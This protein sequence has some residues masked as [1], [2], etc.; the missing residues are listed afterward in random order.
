MTVLSDGWPTEAAGIAAVELV[1]ARINT[2]MTAA[3]F[4]H[5]DAATRVDAVHVRVRGWAADA[6]DT[7]PRTVHLYADTRFVGSTVA[8]AAR[9]D[10][11]D[12]HVGH[13][14]LHG[15]DATFA[16]DDASRVCAYALNAG[17]SAPS[18]LLGCREV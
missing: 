14:E 15:F 16:V 6:S 2:A 12:R 11:A 1:S 10:V 17:P 9:P 3:P 18:S 4:G 7:S 5:L 13:G 8:D